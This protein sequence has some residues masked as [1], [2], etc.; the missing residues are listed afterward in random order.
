MNTTQLAARLKGAFGFSTAKAPVT[1]AVPVFLA[2]GTTPSIANNGALTALT[3]LPTTYSGGIYL[4]FPQGAINAT[5]SGPGYAAGLYYCVMSSTTAGTIYNNIYDPTTG[6][7]PTIP[8][9]PTPFVTTGPGTFTQTTG[10]DIVLLGYKI[11]GESMGLSG[12]LKTTPAFKIINSAGAKVSSVKFGTQSLYSKSR[13][14]S[15]DELPLIEMLSRGLANKQFIPYNGSS[16]YGSGLSAA[17]GYGSADTSIDNNL[18]YI[19]N[20]AVATDYDGLESVRIEQ[21]YGA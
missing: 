20:I 12:S 2:G 7:M 16:T 3:A 15:T 6:L 21:F 1:N 17:G 10:A 9:T 4:Y 13:T 11:I 5:V 8:A 18:T 19:A 14:T